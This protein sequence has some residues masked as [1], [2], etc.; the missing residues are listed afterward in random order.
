MT[1]TTLP[2]EVS[3]GHCSDGT[4]RLYVKDLA[5]RIEFI[6]LTFTYA[7]WGQIVTAGP[8]V[9]L[10]CVVRGLE[11]VGKKFVCEARSIVCDLVS[12][13]INELKDWLAAHGK[14]DGWEIDT[15]LNRRGSVQ[16]KDG[17]RVLHYHVYKYV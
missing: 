3:V 2:V 11:R 1:A 5:S 16:Y 8:S 9:E 12:Y 14:E 15:S 4:I 7:E 17:L 10:E 13:D 6:G